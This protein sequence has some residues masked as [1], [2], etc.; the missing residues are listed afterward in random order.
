MENGEATE[1]GEVM[2]KSAAILRRKTGSSCKKRKRK[3]RGR[4]YLS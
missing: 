1:D 2:G 3:E 4:L